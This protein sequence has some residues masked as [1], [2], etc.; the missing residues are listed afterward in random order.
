MS[1]EKES[2]MK[3]I[4]QEI[5]VWPA[6]TYGT[7]QQAI[8]ITSI[9]SFLCVRQVYIASKKRQPCMFNTPDFNPAY[10]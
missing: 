4:V 7:D 3:I 6:P 9:P 5:Q 2:G 8:L 10:L 1:R